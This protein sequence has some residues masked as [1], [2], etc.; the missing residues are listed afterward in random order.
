MHDMDMTGRPGRRPGARQS[1]VA[2]RTRSKAPV[3]AAKVKAVEP[4][5]L[6]EDEEEEEEEDA[7]S[8]AG[9]G[10]TPADGRWS[11]NATPPP[12]YRARLLSR[13]PWSWPWCGIA[14]ALAVVGAVADVAFSVPPA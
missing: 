9:T 12:E 7:D 1:P 6:Q 8:M 4:A 11:V 2:G 14:L 3:P 5:D 13:C 10:A